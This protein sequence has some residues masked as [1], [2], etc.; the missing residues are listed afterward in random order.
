MRMGVDLF[1]GGLVKHLPLDYV[2]P[3]VMAVRAKEK[4]YIIICLSLLM[5]Y[6]SDVSLHLQL[7]SVQFWKLVFGVAARPSI[8]WRISIGE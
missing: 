7:E 6:S 4:Y 3:P 5:C 8:V 2:R 1:G